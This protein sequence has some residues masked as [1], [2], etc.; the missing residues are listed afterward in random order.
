MI[1]ATRRCG[2]CRYWMNRPYSNGL[3]RIAPPQVASVSEE[4]RHPE[5]GKIQVIKTA[6]YFPRTAAADWCG[7]HRYRSLLAAFSDA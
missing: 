4:I 3:C 2:N 7:Q 1:L 5:R 6:A